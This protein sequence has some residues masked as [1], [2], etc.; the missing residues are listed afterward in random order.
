V[1]SNSF[2]VTPW[3][4]SF[5]P[6]SGT[7]GT[8]VLIHGSGFTNVAAVFFG[9]VSASFTTL[10]LTQ[11]GAVVPVG[12]ESASIS[13]VTPE[14]SGASRDNFLLPPQVATFV[15]ASGGPGD[16]VAITG[17]NLLE[18]TSVRIGGVAAM[19][20]ALSST[21][22]FATVPSGVSD[23]PVVV[24]TPAG[25][26][27]TPNNFRVGVFSDL[28]VGVVSSPDSISIGDFIKYDVTVKNLGPGDANNVVM[29][30]ILPAEV[31]P[32]FSPSGATCVQ[33]NNSIICNLGNLVRGMEVA[34]RVTAQVTDGPYLT[35]QVSVSADS[36]DANPLNNSTSYLTILAGA[37]PPPPPPETNSVTLTVVTIPNG[38]QLTWPA[39]SSGF[40]L[41]S[42]PSL[43]PPVTWI[44]VPVLPV[45]VNGNN[46]VNL[47]SSAGATFYRLRKP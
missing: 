33:N 1:S 36:V 3:V 8:Q 20:T 47:A 19:F 29:T 35:N 6:G 15:P 32:V 31:I 38:L 34:I 7:A 30:E 14:G 37:P 17:T 5:E 46:T 41:E 21:T 25:S 43:V 28:T 4:H 26:A 44:Q 18:T 23:G 9:S 45:V 11:I 10:S 12:A 13:V 24:T 42:A 39:P 22:V 27:T 40:L 2:V 16:S